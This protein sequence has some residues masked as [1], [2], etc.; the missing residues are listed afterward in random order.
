M[1]CSA[2]C[3]MRGRR[4]MRNPIRSVPSTSD[5]LIHGERTDWIPRARIILAQGPNRPFEPFDRFA[6]RPREPGRVSRGSSTN[7][8]ASAPRTYPLRGWQLS[9]RELAL[10][11]EHPELGT[12]TLRQLLATWVAH[13]L[14]HVAHRPRAAKRTA[15][16]RPWRAYPSRCSVVN[17]NL[18]ITQS[19]P[20]VG[21]LPSAERAR[22]VTTMS[23][24]TCGDR[25]RKGEAL[26]CR[27]GGG[28]R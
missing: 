23:N 8:R 2:A 25:C 15:R 16:R 18:P 6:Q 5:D 28:V 3:E 11:G 4:K 20:L 22:L 14:G 19:R 9:D 10:E 27:G 13:D 21:R 24:R 17:G 7:S 26:K 12:V 1:R